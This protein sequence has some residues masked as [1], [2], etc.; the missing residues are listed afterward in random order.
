MHVGAHLCQFRANCAESPPPN[1]FFIR[2]CLIRHFQTILDKSAWDTMRKSSKSAKWP[3]NFLQDCLK[4]TSLWFFNKTQL[5]N[6]VT[7]QMIYSLIK[8]PPSLLPLTPS[9]GK[10][11]LEQSLCRVPTRT[12]TTRT[13]AL[14]NLHI[15][16]TFYTPQT[17]CCSCMWERIYVNFEQTAQNRRPQI[18]FLF[19][20]V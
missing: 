9:M 3:N 12:G 15:H 17:I 10:G 16:Q 5:F 13:R 11:S 20:F 2:F 7:L 19:D 14:F 1:C 4:M 6:F 18:V 8:E